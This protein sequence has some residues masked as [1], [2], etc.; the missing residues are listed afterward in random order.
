MG[1]VR[2]A[3][4]ADI[5]SPLLFVNIWSGRNIWCRKPYLVQEREEFLVN[6]REEYLMERGRNL[7]ERGRNL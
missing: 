1:N 5:S 6:D 3:G 4:D 2:I 7:V